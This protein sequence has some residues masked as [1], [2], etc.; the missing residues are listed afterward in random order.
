MIELDEAV[1]RMLDAKLSLR[2]AQA[3]FRA[4]LWEEAMRRAG[5]VEVRAAKIL[6]AHRNTLSRMRIALE[7][8]PLSKMLSKERNR[9][10]QLI[11]KDL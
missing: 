2:Q 6:R 1:S 4:T 9:K 3:L 5:G 11:T 10:R 8:G 7:E